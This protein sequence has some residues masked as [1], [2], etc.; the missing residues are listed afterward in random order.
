[1]NLKILIVVNIEI[2]VLYLPRV[3]NGHSVKN[4]VEHEICVFWLAESVVDCLAPGTAEFVAFLHGITR[5]GNLVVNKK[6]LLGIL[7]R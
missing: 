1:M 6:S 5:R 2:F 4:C 3:W 7:S